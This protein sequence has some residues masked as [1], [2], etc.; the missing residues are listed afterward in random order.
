MPIDRM[1]WQSNIYAEFVPNWPCP[2][3]GAASLTVV[4]DSFKTGIDGKSCRKWDHP[5][6][7]PQFASGQF[8]CLLKCSKA[9][10]EESC[11]VSGNFDVQECSDEYNTEWYDAGRP[12]SITPPPPLI[13][14]PK[15][16]PLEIRREVEA[17]FGLF[18]L[19]HSSALNRIRNAIELLLTKLGVR[20][21]GKKAGGGRRRLPLDSRIVVL[22]SKKPSLSSLCDRL[23]A[24]KHLGNAGSHPGDVN[25]NDVFDGFDILDQVLNDIYT[26]HA[27]ELAKMVKQINQR[28]GPRNKGP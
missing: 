4:K 22:Q 23:Q 14:I 12:R 10:C 21:Y 18:W 6:F 20:R 2:G 24:V 8:V 9:S 28:K 16:C 15:E 27:S 19:D 26:N 3:C 1:L 25:I 7:E 11:A 13:R 17:A 5:N